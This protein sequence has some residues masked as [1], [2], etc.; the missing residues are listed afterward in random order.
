MGYRPTA[1]GQ[2]LLREAEDVES[3]TIGL[4]SRL[5]NMTS[6]LAGAVRVDTP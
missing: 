2:Q 1:A 3:L 5:T 6:E 4:Q